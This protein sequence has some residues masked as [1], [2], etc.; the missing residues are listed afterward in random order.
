MRR[1]H[2]R[3]HMTH[4]GQNFFQDCGH[5]AGIRIGHFHG[6]MEQ[7]F[8]LFS[9]NGGNGLVQTPPP[10][11]F[12]SLGLSRGIAAL[13]LYPFHCFLISPHTAVTTPTVI[14]VTRILS[15]QLPM[16]FL[17]A[18][19]WGTNLEMSRSCSMPLR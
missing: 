1:P 11:I 17:A 10:F 15:T 7:F 18:I 5:H 13:S 14:E 6:R 19:T 2:I 9:L 12:G 3:L 16:E 8:S 4:V